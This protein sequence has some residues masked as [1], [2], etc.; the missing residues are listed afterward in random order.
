MTTTTDQIMVTFVPVFVPVTGTNAKRPSQGIMKK[1]LAKGV[2][3]FSGEDRTRTPAENAGKTAILVQSGAKSGALSAEVGSI[4]PDLEAIVEC[5]PNLSNA[6]KASILAM[7][8]AAK[9]E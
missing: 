9:A 6:V 2:Q 1:Q 5:W 7:V 8:T 3:N 4:D